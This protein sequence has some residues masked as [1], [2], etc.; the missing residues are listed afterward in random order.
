MTFN[1]SYA[2][3]FDVHWPDVTD[4]MQRCW[5]DSINATEHAAYGVSFLLML[6][7]TEFT[8]I[9]RSMIG[10]GFDYWLGT[11]DGLFQRKAR[12]EVSGILRG[13][14]QAVQARVRLKKKQTTPT[15][16]PLPA[17]I[18]VVEFSAP[19]SSVVKK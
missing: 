8:V 15:D 4:Q 9:E 14:E 7:L 16:G 18:V 10:T 13:D 19:A 17:Y 1:G 5:N 2:A 11:D 6:E 12:L 3:S